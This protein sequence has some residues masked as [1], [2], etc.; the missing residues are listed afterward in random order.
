MSETLHIG[1][2]WSLGTII[3]CSALV[4]RLALLLKIWMAG[5]KK[6]GGPSPRPIQGCSRLFK[7]EK[8]IRVTEEDIR[9]GRTE[10]S[11]IEHPTS[12]IEMSVTKESCERTLR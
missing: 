6:I 4:N 8:E 9:G 7:V 3:G 2:D 12:N 10:T 5:W 1:D 11:N